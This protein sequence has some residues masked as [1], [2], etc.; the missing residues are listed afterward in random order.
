MYYD[1]KR[2]RR[3]EESESFYAKAYLGVIKAAD[4]PHQMNQVLSAQPPPP[5]QKH[6]NVKTMKTAQIKPDG[7]FYAPD[8][9]RSPM[10]K[11]TEWTINQAV[12]ALYAS[13]VLK[14]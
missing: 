10:I 14:K 3:P 8:E 6:Y 7:I 1:T 13:G 2:G 9:P 5:K 12:P 4:Y 11:C